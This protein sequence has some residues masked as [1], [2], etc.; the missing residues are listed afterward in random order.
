L[1]ARSF[2]TFASGR[3]VADLMSA[4]EVSKIR[5]SLLQAKQL[6]GGEQKAAAAT[7]A[8]ELADAATAGKPV[9]AVDEGGR[10]S[11]A[12]PGGGGAEPSSEPDTVVETKPEGE[13]PKAEVAWEGEILKAEVAVEGE[14]PMDIDVP[15]AALEVVDEEVKAFW[16]SGVAA[17]VE[18]SKQGCDEAVVM[19]TSGEVWFV[20]LI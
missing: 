16:L 14:V 18:V 8:K 7:V 15:E 3:Q 2:K 10:S 17:V 4:G 5:A 11:G 12:S 19:D 13:L 9:A 20:F 1:S 6:A